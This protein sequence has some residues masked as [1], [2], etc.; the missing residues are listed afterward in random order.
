MPGIIGT[1]SEQTYGRG[2]IHTPSSPAP[3]APS[4]PLQGS[5]PYGGGGSS[6]SGSP[7][8]A[9]FAAKGQFLAVSGAA[10]AK[11]AGKFSV[12]AAKEAGYN[13][14]ANSNAPGGYILV[15]GGVVSNIYGTPLYST[16]PGSPAIGLSTSGN[17]SLP[18]GFRKAGTAIT[19]AGNP[20]GM[21]KSGN[22]I[23]LPALIH[24]PSLTGQP[25][26]SPGITYAEFGQNAGIYNSAGGINKNRL[27][28]DTG[29]FS[30]NED[31]G[32]RRYTFTGTVPI[33]GGFTSEANAAVD[34][35]WQQYTANLPNESGIFVAGTA[36]ATLPSGTVIRIP[37]AIKSATYNT[38]S[39]LI[40]PGAFTAMGRG[41]TAENFRT[42]YYAFVKPNEQ[43]FSSL[44]DVQNPAYLASL[45]GDQGFG[46]AYIG[47]SLSTGNGV[48][49]LS[50]GN[51]IDTFTLPR[52][53]VS[54]TTSS[55]TNEPWVSRTS[56]S[57][58]SNRL[59]PTRSQSMWQPSVYPKTESQDKGAG[60]AN[61]LPSNSM[62][63]R[64]FPDT[65]VSYASGPYNKNGILSN[66]NLPKG[67]PTLSATNT[68]SAY[69]PLEG[70]SVLSDISN[71]GLVY[72]PM[73]LTSPL[74][75]TSEPIRAYGYFRN[76]ADAFS[77]YYTRAVAQPARTS[78]SH[79][80]G[81]Y[82]ATPVGQAAEAAF[83]TIVGTPAALAQ[84][85]AHPLRA[86]LYE[87]GF[88]THLIGHPL[89][90]LNPQIGGQVAAQ[91]ATLGLLGAASDAADA[92]RF[93]ISPTLEGEGVPAMRIVRYEPQPSAGTGTIAHTGLLSQTMDYNNPEF[94]ARDFTK[95]ITGKISVEGPGRYA[96]DPFVYKNGLAIS[97]TTGAQDFLT[98]EGAANPTDILGGNLRRTTTG[99]ATSAFR[100]ALDRYLP[101]IK[102]R[103]YNIEENVPVNAGT[104]RITLEKGGNAKMP[105]INIG[106]Q[107]IYGAE[108]PATY[109]TGSFTAPEIGILQQVG[110]AKE[111]GLVGSYHLYYKP[112]G[113]GPSYIDVMNAREGSML[114]PHGIDLEGKYSPGD[115]TT[116]KQLSDAKSV[117]LS[118]VTREDMS[119]NPVPVTMIK[120]ETP[121]LARPAFTPKIIKGGVPPAPRPFTTPAEAPP[122]IGDSINNIFTANREGTATVQKTAPT[123]LASIAPAPQ[124]ATL[125]VL[126]QA[127][128]PATLASASL[129]GD[130]NT[131]RPQPATP[132]L[133]FEPAAPSAAQADITILN[134]LNTINQVSLQAYDRNQYNYI[135][136]FKGLSPQQ[137]YGLYEQLTAPM[138]QEVRKVTNAINTMMGEIEQ[139][140][141][142]QTAMRDITNEITRLI[143]LEQ[144]LDLLNV[145]DR[146]SLMNNFYPLELERYGLA[147]S[148]SQK[149]KRTQK[150]SPIQQEIQSTTT[151]PTPVPP[152]PPAKGSI[153]P[154]SQNNSLWY[155]PSMQPP[156]LAKLHQP[157]AEYH[158]SVSAI[159]LPDLEPEFERNYN[160]V[161][162][163]V[164]VRPL[165]EPKAV[166]ERLK[167]SY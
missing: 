134:N 43:K 29:L 116:L 128:D 39:G 49:S 55:T 117:G 127:I 104:A 54:S 100:T 16:S 106:Q 40:T 141:I 21:T 105:I 84:T 125:A 81:N 89:S 154:P 56:L 15:K 98:E 63:A 115:I 114:A 24:K 145:T 58:T 164:L 146:S 144:R 32:G 99:Y 83:G 67:V 147:Q 165:K 75:P 160:D 93:Q 13:V 41:S 131:H 8:S 151:V 28:P 150:T 42:G 153:I 79:A 1:G 10:T 18:S 6:S 92:I 68:A 19:Y 82:N 122:P 46:P 132:G 97:K 110:E 72:G 124:P 52:G 107:P 59:W 162:A 163:G 96:I 136:Q 3:P 138:N 159:T 119:T 103:A 167:R 123:Q 74:S 61:M 135:S 155:T 51:L 130:L 14:L 87:M 143:D 48:I 22:P 71:L 108:M 101:G 69:H 7:T 102:Y 112:Q 78:Y 11:P 140:N 31:I 120:V 113:F 57:G 20:V 149:Q 53:W 62:Q 90:I 86:I 121:E 76:A 70:A 44:A 95:G 158:P 166:R 9:D 139:G 45:A 133:I 2:S 60:V 157:D 126:P 94:Y 88:G 25:Y 36:Y 156:K 4:Q 35:A 137:R 111:P 148:N 38:D 47:K 5:S 27:N 80:L 152:P 50:N 85:V 118:Y 30:F 34:K 23:P 73:L 33:K 66:I 12:S 77:N 91:V 26:I 37:S 65:T 109:S 161:L 129:A 142:S 64:I 17:Y